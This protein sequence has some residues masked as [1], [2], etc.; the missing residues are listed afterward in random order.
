[1][2]V[3]KCAKIVRKSRILYSNF[4]MSEIDAAQE[5]HLL[6]VQKYIVEIYKADAQWKPW[7]KQNST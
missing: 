7:H 3:L 4:K 2:K 5:A 1:M 6:E